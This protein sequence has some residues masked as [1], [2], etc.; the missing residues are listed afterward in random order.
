MVL[1]RP[2]LCDPVFAFRLCVSWRI[3]LCFAWL[4]QSLLKDENLFSGGESFLD[5]AFIEARQPKPH[6]KRSTKRKLTF[7]GLPQ[8][9]SS[10]G[11]NE[12]GAAASHL[13]RLNFHA[14][15][16]QRNH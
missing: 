15:V 3:S 13:V 1:A 10:V 12:R 9:V 5:F 4:A 11:K 6:T 16:G 8:L 14:E 7:K 2:G